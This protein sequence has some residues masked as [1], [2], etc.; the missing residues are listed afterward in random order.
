MAI[1]F[2]KGLNQG[3]NDQKSTAIRL[4]Q[5]IFINYSFTLSKYSPLLVLMRMSSPSFTKSGT[6]TVEPV[7]TVA[8]FKVRVAVSPL[9]PGSQ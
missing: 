9:I 7:S 1:L 6:F 5:P 3:N 4:L 2:E 8:G